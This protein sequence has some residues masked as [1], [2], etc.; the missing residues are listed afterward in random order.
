MPFINTYHRIKQV[1]SFAELLITPFANVASS[2]L[3]FK[4]L[5]ITVAGCLLLVMSARSRA[6]FSGALP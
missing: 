3:V 5:T 1:G 4:P 2:G 6:I